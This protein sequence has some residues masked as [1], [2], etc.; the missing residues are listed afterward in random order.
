MS[1]VI[2]ERPGGRST[3]MQAD[4]DVFTRDT[5]TISHNDPSFDRRGPWQTFKPGSWLSATA[6]DA[7][8]DLPLYSFQ[9]VQRQREIDAVVAKYQHA[10]RTVA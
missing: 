6:F 7:V 1:Y 3:F 9:S 5:L 8:N 4:A 10:E 2:V